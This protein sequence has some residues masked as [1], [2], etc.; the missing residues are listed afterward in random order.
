MSSAED[1]DRDQDEFSGEIN[2]SAELQLGQ[3]YWNQPAQPQDQI[4]KQLPPPTRPVVV[5]RP[6]LT[7]V[8]MYES[9]CARIKFAWNFN[10][11]NLEN[12]EPIDTGLGNANFPVRKCLI[13]VLN[14][15]ATKELI[16]LGDPNKIGVH[17]IIPTRIVMES[18]ENTSDF[19][20]IVSANWFNANTK[21]VSS[22]GQVGIAH[23]PAA[24]AHVAPNY[25]LYDSTATPAIDMRI[26]ELLGNNNIFLET[27]G[28]DS[29][30]ALE[31]EQ[32]QISANPP[33]NVVAVNKTTPECVLL[34]EHSVLGHLF[35]ASVPD[36]LP[37]RVDGG[38]NWY[39]MDLATWGGFM[40]FFKPKFET[41]RSVIT[42]LSTPVKC[43]LAFD[44]VNL[45]NTD[46]PV[47]DFNL[48]KTVAGFISSDAERNTFL[49]STMI[50]VVVVFN[51]N[52]LV[53]YKTVVK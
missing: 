37:T 7:N 6:Q 40:S 42:N 52:Y 32:V 15:N 23:I 44:L 26:S 41:Y 2:I 47:A 33:R 34:Y 51:V 20:F 45:A 22:T 31:N 16:N 10:L 49:K 53:P 1:Q 28:F 8:K 50:R 29:I 18:I 12:S 25:E 43:T 11:N 13:S 19:P 9:K 30:A 3:S 39:G 24:P 27:I 21:I 4:I 38:L 36:V 46:N 48:S 5:S 35:K 17:N 14:E